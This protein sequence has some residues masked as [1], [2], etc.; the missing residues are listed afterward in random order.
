MND[1]A[2]TD[3]TAGRASLAF[4]CAGLPP[5]WPE[6]VRRLQV[7]LSVMHPTYARAAWAQWP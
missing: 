5:V 1:L 7:V 6:R 2:Q 4:V 3:A